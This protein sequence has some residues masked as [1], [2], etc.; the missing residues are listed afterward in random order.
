MTITGNSIDVVDT[1]VTLTTDGDAAYVWSVDG[2]RSG[3]GTTTAIYKF[4]GD[5]I[6]IAQDISVTANGILGTHTLTVYDW[7]ARGELKRVIDAVSETGNVYAYHRW[8]AL[9]PD[10]INIFQTII[11]GEKTIRAWMVNG[12][13]P[14]LSEQIEFGY[15]P[16]EKNTMT[17]E[18]LGY[19][20]W[21]DDS[22]SQMRAGDMTRKVMAAINADSVLHSDLFYTVDLVQLIAFEP[23]MLANILVH[24][25]RLTI[26]ITE[27]EQ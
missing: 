12:P 18:I 25:A 23:V 11:D 2:L 19:F 27:Y 14:L 8:A 21:N 13:G 24:R 26:E 10:I 4:S 5:Q 17:W 15:P 7:R 9:R 16:A 3:Q 22:I 6:G 20:A 1:N